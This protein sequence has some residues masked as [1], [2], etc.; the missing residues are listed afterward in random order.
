MQS[1]RHV[2]WDGANLLVMDL[3][4]ENSEQS[5]RSRLCTMQSQLLHAGGCLTLQ[6]MTTCQAGGLALLGGGVLR[7]LRAA[8]RRGLIAKNAEIVPE[9]AS[10]YMM[11]MQSEWIRVTKNSIHCKYGQKPVI[12]RKSGKGN[13]LA[14]KSRES[15]PPQCYKTQNANGDLEGYLKHPAS[16]PGWIGSLCCTNLSSFPM[17][18]LT[19][20]ASQGLLLRALVLSLAAGAVNSDLD[21]AGY[22]TEKDADE[23]AAPAHHSASGGSVLHAKESG[24]LSKIDLGPINKYRWDDAPQAV[25]LSRVPHT[26]LTPIIHL[27]DIDFCAVAAS[28]PSLQGIT[29]AAHTVSTTGAE[30]SR[31]GGEQVVRARGSSAAATAS[32]PATQQGVLNSACLW[33]TL[34][35]NDSTSITSAEVGME[36]KGE[37]S[38]ET[39]QGEVQQQQEQSSPSF[40]GQA[41]LYLDLVLPVEPGQVG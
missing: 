24:L 2:P 38:Q 17:S 31:F 19:K 29:A 34:Q 20:P 37:G 16:E 8:A 32:V 40:W 27:W 25:R 9:R 18:L 21:A 4:D 41:L 3:F 23:K 7:M 36:Q 15:P 26:P 28:G 22:Q 33:F 39:K 30:V 10:M 35:L 11:G 12:K 13:T 1:G 14:Q 5:M 6:G